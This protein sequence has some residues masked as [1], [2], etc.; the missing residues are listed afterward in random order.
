MKD[1]IKFIE[2]L[3]KSM[4]E[5]KIEAVKY[6]DSNFEISLTKKRKER[7]IVLG[8]ALSQPQPLVQPAAAEN[9]QEEAETPETAAPAEQK[10]VAPEEISGT[11]I[12]SPMVGTF[13]TS[14]SPTAAPFVKEGDSVKEGQTLCIVEAMKLMN[15]V[16]STVTGKIKKVLVK[17]KDSIKKGQVL[18]I[19]E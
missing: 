9:I 3:A 17:D 2:E 1:K 5:N 4:N 16:K 18:F 8:G 6:E 11:K 10:E 19:V 7:N 12:T 13:Y 15:E 14:P